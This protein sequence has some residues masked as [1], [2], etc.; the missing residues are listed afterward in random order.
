M[1]TIRVS[2]PNGY[3]GVLYGESS[4]SIYYDGREVLHTGFRS[5]NTKEEL[6]KRL[7]EMPEFIAMLIKT[8]EEY[9][10]HNG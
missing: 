5:I 6:Y 10:K 8:S 1:T 9:R 4:M 2:H 7:E 3:S